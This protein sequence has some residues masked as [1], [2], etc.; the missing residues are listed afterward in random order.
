MNAQV[1]ELQLKPTSL[2]IIMKL[3]F[4]LKQR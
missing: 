4:S 1:N 3:K 2:N